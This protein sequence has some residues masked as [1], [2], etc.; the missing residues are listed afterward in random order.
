MKKRLHT[1]FIILALGIFLV[2]AVRLVMIWAGYQ[3]SKNIQQAA[4]QEYTRVSSGYKPDA[5]SSSAVSGG[6]Q[7]QAD[8]K[9]CA[10]IEVDFAKLKE[11]SGDVVGWIYCEGTP[12]N[13]PVVFGRDNEYYLERNYLGDYD[14]SGA[15]FTDMRNERGFA[16]YNVILYGHHMQDGSM[17]A[18][19][20]N[21]Y[22]QAYYEAHPEMWL[23]TPEQDYRVELFA[24]YL[25]TTDSDTYSVFSEGG[26]RLEAYLNWAKRW[27]AFQSDVET[28]PD[29]HY[30]VLSTC[31]YS[32]DDARTALHG[33]LVPVDS[34]GGVPPA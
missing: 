7:T 3:K 32:S 10:P 24:G 18:S 15:I 33:K 25:T 16:D 21:W 31:A 19:L 22:D 4:V 26:E 20:K 12:I 8:E 30:I 34:A 28:P 27:S 6:A 14:P 5:G 17:F 13:Y 9:V 11:A 2:S 1:V 23:L 29:G